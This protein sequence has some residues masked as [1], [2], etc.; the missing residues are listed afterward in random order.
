M[1]KR[2]STLRAVPAAPPPKPADEPTTLDVVLPTPALRVALRRLARVLDDGPLPLVRVECDE[3]GV[4]L[5]ATDLTHFARFRLPHSAPRGLPPTDASELARATPAG[6]GS[7]VLLATTLRAL[8]RKGRDSNGRDASTRLRAYADGRLRDGWADGP[9]TSWRDNVA[10]L[11]LPPAALPALP[12]SAGRAEGIAVGP[13]GAAFA[14]VAHAMSH[15]ATRPHLAGACLQPHGVGMRV[16]ATDGHRLASA[17]Y[18]TELGPTLPAEVVI[19]RGA[20]ALVAEL[21]GDLFLLDR[22]TYVAFANA[23]GDFV[24][25]WSDAAARPAFPAI[26]Q[27]VPYDGDR[28]I[29][30]DAAALVAA[31]REATAKPTGGIDGGVALH[32]ADGG[33]RVE[34]EAPD[35]KDAT[36]TRVVFVDVAATVTG[37]P[38]RIGVNATYLLDALAATGGTVTITLSGELDPIKFVSPGDRPVTCVVMPMRV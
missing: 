15:D 31:V 33:L 38:R 35:P 13:A 16:S 30:V 22:G 7:A 8:A 28:K 20:A 25:W 3:H 34:G 9:A 32:I 36:K 11:A 1:T 14:R 21:P 4:A 37:K 12:P 23:A 5:T 27:V 17:H 19:P 24:A 18:P 6:T 26:D 10:R 29:T 2:T